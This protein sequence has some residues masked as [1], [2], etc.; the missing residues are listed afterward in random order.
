MSS[1]RRERPAHEDTC[2][3]SDGR[4]LVGHYTLEFLCAQILDQDFFLWLDLQEL[5][6]ET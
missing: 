1:G 3:V 2:V 5:E 4:E 6:Q